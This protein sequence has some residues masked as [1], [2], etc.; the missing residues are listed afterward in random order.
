MEG[1]FRVGAV[2]IIRNVSGTGRVESETLPVNGC[3]AQYHVE[4]DRASLS[5]GEKRLIEE[6]VRPLPDRR[7]LPISD[8]PYE[9]DPLPK[10]L[11]N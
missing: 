10:E 5:D 3:F 7:I 1:Q 4:G 9:V 2:S 8:G 6:G 11:A